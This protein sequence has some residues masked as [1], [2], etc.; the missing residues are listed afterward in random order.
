MRRKRRAPSRLVGRYFALIA[1]LIIAISL[2]VQSLRP[3]D[4]ATA[5]DGL[6]VLY[7]LRGQAA[8][9]CGVDAQAA[10]IGARER[11]ALTDGCTVTTGPGAEAA[12]S[13]DHGRVLL[14]LGPNAV[15][16]QGAVERRQIGRTLRV[17]AT[18]EQG[19]ITGWVDGGPL[20]SASVM[21]QVG[22]AEV[23][24][25]GG[26][27]EA[28]ANDANSARM[29]VYVGEARAS[30]GRHAA[31]LAAGQEAGLMRDSAITPLQTAGEA[32]QRPDLPDDL[33]AAPTST[34]RAVQGATAT[35]TPAQAWQ[36]YTVQPDDTLSTIA[37]A[38][39]LTW[40]QLWEANRDEVPDPQLLMAGQTL[41]IPARGD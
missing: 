27:F 14:V 32:P 21:L 3:G 10:P 9:A 30:V 38:H 20:D 2:L 23:Y 13:V 39:G 28:V 6:Q 1:L 29:A 26:L 36:L 12:L 16:A 22:P 25:G 41:R 33:L 24:C 19:K 18:V 35:Q 7:V 37:E 17:A 4:R 15:Y 31:T 34:P 5:S 40:Q 8:V 11:A